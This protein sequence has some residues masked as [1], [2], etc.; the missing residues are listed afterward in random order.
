M[1]TFLSFEWKRFWGDIKNKVAF[2]I[3]MG[4]SLYLVF[5]VEKDYEAVRSFDS[6]PIEATHQDASYFLDTREA[7]LYPRSF[8]AFG[9]LK[10]VSGELLQALKQE[11]YREAITI[12]KEYQGLMMERYRSQDPRYYLYGGRHYDRGR[13]QSYD[14]TTYSLY[15]DYLLES[16]LALN[17]EIL[18]GKTVGQSLTRAWSGVMPLIFI[19]LALVFSIDFF[20]SDFKHRSLVD[21]FPLST[22]K[23]SWLRSGVSWSATAFTLLIGELVFII[24]LSFFRSWGGIDLMVDG[25]LNPLSVGAF[26]LKAHILLFL[27]ILILLRI[28]SWTGELFRNSLVPILLIPSLI[29]PYLFELSRSEEFGRLFE[30]IPLSFIQPGD[31]VSGFQSF[32]QDSSAFTFG[33]E[34]FL[35]GMSLFFLEL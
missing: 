21:A 2:L 35:L 7:E 3:V 9:D 26:L 12:E 13:L 22:Y 14:Q 25:I 16:N 8:K 18:E 5:G 19:V 32:W 24:A 27:A 29:L 4:L 33:R 31:I 20:A 1:R 30:W 34:L 23:K 6:E 28:A 10:E 11:D 15:S 17:Q